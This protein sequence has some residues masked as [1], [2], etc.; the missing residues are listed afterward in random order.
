MCISGG[1]TSRLFAE[2]PVSDAPL[3]T[4]QFTAL[5]FNYELCT[6]LPRFPTVVGSILQNE[7]VISGR[8]KAFSFEIAIQA[9]HSEL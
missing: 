7:K 1:E 9:V 5:S 8:F 4:L 6:D 3:L 2:F